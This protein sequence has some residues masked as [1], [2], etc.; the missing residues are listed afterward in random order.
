MNSEQKIVVDRKCASHSHN[1]DSDDQ[2]KAEQRA[3]HSIQAKRSTSEGIPQVPQGLSR[4]LDGKE[5]ALRGL[6][7]RKKYPELPRV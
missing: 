1:L 4:V 5:R 7:R 2:N 3:V 6:N